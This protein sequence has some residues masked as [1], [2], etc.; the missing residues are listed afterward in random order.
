MGVPPVRAHP[1]KETGMAT[2]G[3]TYWPWFLSISGFWV[4][5]AFGIP[6]GLA[7]ATHP[8]HHVDNTLSFYARHEL[9]VGIATAGNIH[10]LAWWLSFLMW[11]MFVIFITGHIW[12]DQWG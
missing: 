12:M 4:L 8:A 10:T 7:L 3:S 1:G 11:M 9:H 5:T 2:W 6:E